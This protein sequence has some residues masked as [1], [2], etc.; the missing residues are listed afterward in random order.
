MGDGPGAGMLLLRE[1]ACLRVVRQLCIQG[2]ESHSARVILA[3]F[4]PVLSLVGLLRQS[5]RAGL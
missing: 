4:V 5:G 3:L 1:R 2:T